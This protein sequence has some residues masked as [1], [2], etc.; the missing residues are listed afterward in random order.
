MGRQVFRHEVP[1]DDRDHV[2]LMPPS[3]IVKVGCRNPDRVEFRYLHTGAND[4]PRT[5]RVFGTG[6][7]VYDA[8]TYVGTAE[9]V[10]DGAIVW[11]L[12][13]DVGA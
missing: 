4:I 6:H 3:Q 8:Y 9:P 10:A 5:F 11:H 2:I 7:P 12:F 13:E 1:V